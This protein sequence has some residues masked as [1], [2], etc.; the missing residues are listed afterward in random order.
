M[1]KISRADLRR[2]ANKYIRER[3]CHLSPGRCEPDHGLSI[4]LEELAQLKEGA[5]NPSEALVAALL[6]LFPG[7]VP[8]ADIYT[9]L[10]RPFTNEKREQ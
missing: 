9:H 5:A 10:I 1:G 3:L 2:E 6:Q 7:K 4:P 8:E